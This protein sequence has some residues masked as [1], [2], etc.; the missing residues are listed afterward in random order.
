MKEGIDYD[1]VPVSE[2]HRQAWDVRFLEGPFPETVIRF[3]NIAFDGEDGCLHFNFM[4]QSTP[5]GDLNEDNTELQEHAAN[6]LENILADAA[7]DGSLQYGD[8]VENRS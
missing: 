8:E 7:N 5:D 2:E 1:L 4:I 6:V 3:G